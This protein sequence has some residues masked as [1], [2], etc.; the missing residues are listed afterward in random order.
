MLKLVKELC[1]LDGVSSWEDQ[2][3]DFIRAK[4]EPYA[5]SIRTDAI[6]NLIV[7]KRG[8][9]HT[10]T[11]L[12]LAAHMDEVGLM[13]RRIEED[14][15][16]RFDTVGGI[17]RRVLIGKRVWVGS[18]RVPAVIGSKPVHLT[19]KEERKHVPKLEELY[20]DLGAE[21]REAA[22]KL[23][24]LGDVAC[25]DPEC[26]TFG[27]GML[28]A[29]AI[30][31]RIGCAVLLKLLEEELPLDCTFVFSA[32]EE[33][34]TRGAFGYAFSV[35]PEI[36]LVVEGTTAADI[37]GTPEHQQVCAPGRG[38]VISLM[39]GGTIYDRGLFETLRDLADAHQIPWQVKH[40][41][42]G[43]TDARTI[44]RSRSG[45][46]VA[47]LAAAVRNI[48]SPSSVAAIA[49]FEPLLNLSR[50]FLQAI[51]QEV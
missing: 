6:G 22:E 36:A 30:D 43:G 29:K 19:T 14:G 49:D 5:D 11:K 21:D 9:K 3:R 24:S 33:V 27:G 2:V 48:H 45:V 8:K 1:A 39:D 23:V 16:L 34:G 35:A 38:P 26:V 42:A 44:Q 41:I 4:S 37:P 13:I 15:A 51:A 40:M 10:G 47:G 7:F 12:L 50:L 46:R 28:K 25:F 31:D 17:D 18:N 20:L 32:Q